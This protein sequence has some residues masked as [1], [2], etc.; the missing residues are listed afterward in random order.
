MGVMPGIG[1]LGRVGAVD[2]EGKYIIRATSTITSLSKDIG[3]TWATQYSGKN[4]TAS[5]ISSD[6]KYQLLGVSSEYLY[7]SSDYG[8][9]WGVAYNSYTK[10]Y[11]DCA[12]SSTG[13]YQYAL[14]STGIYLI[15]STD[16]GATWTDSVAYMGYNFGTS[17][18]CSSNGQYVIVTRNNTTG[19]VL[20]SSNYGV[21]FTSITSTVNKYWEHGACDYTGQYMIAVG[22]LDANSTTSHVIYSSDYGAS[23]TYS[24]TIP[25]GRPYV[26]RMSFDGAYSYIGAIGG[27]W[28]STN[29]GVTWTSKYV[30]ICTRLGISKTGKYIIAGSLTGNNIPSISS[31]GGTSFTATGLNSLIT[32]SLKINQ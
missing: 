14:A 6:G 32:T 22:R 1:V 8:V 28:V 26:V 3:S 4:I 16:Y 2:T 13:Q 9:T 27:L 11:I 23:F 15:R 12:I 18:S 21:S 25:T 10:Y 24:T 5:A 19:S 17:I 30:I 20:V 31:N 29:K 7:K